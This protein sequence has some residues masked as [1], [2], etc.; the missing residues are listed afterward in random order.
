[1]AAAPEE[2]GWSGA[3]ELQLACREMDSP[4]VRCHEKDDHQQGLVTLLAGVRRRT[5]VPRVVA[6]D[7]LAFLESLG[8]LYFIFSRVYWSREFHFEVRVR[9]SQKVFAGWHNVEL[10]STWITGRAKC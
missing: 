7:L 2:L 6:I 8:R 4:F 3:L 9:D 1:M 10:L 5:K